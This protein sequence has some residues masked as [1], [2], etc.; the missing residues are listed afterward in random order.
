MSLARVYQLM[1]KYPKSL[2]VLKRLKALNY[3][4]DKPGSGATAI[5]EGRLSATHLS[6]NNKSESLQHAKDTLNRVSKIQEVDPN[7]IGKW[8]WDLSN[9]SLL[10]Y[11]ELL[12]CLA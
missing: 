5:L 6:L 3:E 7:N 2:D 11:S 8:Q 9:A 10:H 12:R 1:G 4:Y